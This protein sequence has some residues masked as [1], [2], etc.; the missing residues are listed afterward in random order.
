MNEKLMTVSELAEWLHLSQATI[1]AKIKEH[2]IPFKHVG[3]RYRFSRKDIEEWI[4]ESPVEE[5]IQD[6]P[7]AKSL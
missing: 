5:E 1:Y 6:A 4:K 3:K 2:S 7:E